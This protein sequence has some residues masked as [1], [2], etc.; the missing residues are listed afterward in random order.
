M[1]S[2]ID[3]FGSIAYTWPLSPARNR[4]AKRSE[5]GLVGVSKNRANLPQPQQI[6]Q[7]FHPLIAAREQLY[8]TH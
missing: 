6:I 2:L 5:H 4:Q 7:G 3:F 8:G 1:S